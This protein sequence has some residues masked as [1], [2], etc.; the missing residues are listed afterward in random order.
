[1]EKELRLNQLTPEEE[2]VLIHKW[3]EMPFTGEL[4]EEKREGTFVCKQCDAPLYYSEMKFESGC[5]RPSFDDAIPGQVHEYVDADGRRV[6]ITCTTCGGHLWHVFRGEKLT[7]K[8][9]RHCVNSVSMK[10]VEGKVDMLE[11]AVHNTAD[12]ATFGWG[13]YRCVEA[14]MQRLR[15][16]I[17]VESGFMWWATDD[18]TYDDVSYDETGHVEV[19]HIHFDPEL[20]TYQTLLNVFFSSHNP[21]QLNAQGNDKGTQYASV[22]FTH[23]PEQASQAQQMIQQLNESDIY[24]PETVV[25][26]VREASDFWKWPDAH[27]D[28]YNNNQWDRYCEFV[29]NPKIKKLRESYADLLKDEEAESSR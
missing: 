16:V 22:I 15:W 13:C 12:V 1:M 20:I 25:T 10:F 4:L 21:T 23:S 2:R 18:P 9:T 27:Q 24:T 26:Q 5:G 28:Y 8:D 19:V 7:E 29:I 14:V 11:H 17:Q 3:T 6:E